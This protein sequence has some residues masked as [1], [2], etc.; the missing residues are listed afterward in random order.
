[1]QLYNVS[2]ELNR[3]FGEPGTD[4]RR[5]AE[6]QAWEEYYL[7]TFNVKKDYESKSSKY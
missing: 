5:Q 3:I 6:N 7:K 4:A 1:M 2:E